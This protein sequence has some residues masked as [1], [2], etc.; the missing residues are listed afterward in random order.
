MAAQYD[1][2][3]HC[4]KVIKTLLQASAEPY[5]VIILKT[6]WYYLSPPKQTATNNVKLHDPWPI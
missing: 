5:Y 6:I 4:I 2:P 1:L 3:F